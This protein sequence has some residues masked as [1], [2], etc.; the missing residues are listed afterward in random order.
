MSGT[1]VTASDSGGQSTP[2]IGKLGVRDPTAA[3]KSSAGLL[4]GAFGSVLTVVGI[5]SGEMGSILRNDE[6]KV[7]VVL[8]ILVVS[9]V[10]AFLSAVIGAKAQWSKEGVMGALLLIAS[11]YA[12][13]ISVFP[14]DDQNSWTVTRILAAGV[15]GL[16]F[17]VAA[18]ALFHSRSDLTSQQEINRLPPEKQGSRQESL[19]G[20]MGE[21]TTNASSIEGA[22]GIPGASG[23]TGGPVRVNLQS[24][25][26]VFSGLLLALAVLGT[27]RIEARNQQDDILQL[28]P[29]VAA[30]DE[31]NYVVVSV[32]VAAP[33]L[34]SRQQVVFTMSG[35]IRSGDTSKK[36]SVPIDKVRVRPDVTGLAKQTILVP[37]SLRRFTQVVGTATI[38]VSDTPAGFAM[39][40]FRVH[41]PAPT[42][43][44]RSG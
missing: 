29:S 16:L 5:N 13:V 36:I 35:V 33:R 37:V 9:I 8:L 10:L 24:W 3:L 15:A 44:A 22:K 6:W 12:L 34:S 32:T 41:L 27:I 4:L 11:C 31:N 18:R 2:Q 25:L 1:S 19:A 26:I 40:A 38:N 20:R 21:P 30:P 23:S 28:T 14:L 7:L 42:A 17:V 39:S 43:S